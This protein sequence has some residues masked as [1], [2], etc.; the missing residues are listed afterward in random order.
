MRT[1]AWFVP[2]SAPQ[3]APIIP[4]DSWA[5]DRAAAWDLLFSFRKVSWLMMAVI[6]GTMA[7]NAFVSRMIGEATERVFGSGDLHDVIAPM[8]T[9]TV[10]ML[11][12]F[13]GEATT[14]AFTDLTSAR[15][16]H[17]LRLGLTDRLMN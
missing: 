6:V 1:W 10:L 8:V 14:D 11:V 13:V 7:A 17:R 3:E 15:T 9:F 4:E 2:D 16:I 12:L 5:S